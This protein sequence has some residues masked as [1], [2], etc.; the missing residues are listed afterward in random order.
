MSSSINFPPMATS[1]V[2]KAVIPPIEQ[3]SLALEYAELTHVISRGND[4]P[5]T[6]LLDGGPGIAHYL[7]EFFEPLQMPGCLIGFDPFGT[8][9]TTTPSHMIPTP[10]N[11]ALQFSGLILK[12]AKPGQQIKIIAHSFGA[13]ILRLALDQVFK[14]NSYD[15]TLLLIDPCPFTSWA[16]AESATK[17][18]LKL[19]EGGV[20]E[21]ENSL[22]QKY[23]TAIAEN[24]QEAINS[25]GAEMLA[26]E[27]P[28]Y[29]SE[30]KAIPMAIPIC[31]NPYNPIF[32]NSVETHFTE[33]YALFDW[34]DYP[35]PT[36][37]TVVAGS[38]DP[39]RLGP[40]PSCIIQSVVI[41]DAGHYSYVERPEVFL[42]NVRTI[43][44]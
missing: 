33:Q 19:K 12:Y 18:A 32:E 38:N 40:L 10:E 23:N 8:G 26:L 29:F 4:E 16:T 15:L 27:M 5:I 14:W 42:D 28:Y 22:Q 21:K 35:Y 37:T 2:H 3:M 24:N 17:L 43:L 9:A 25:I 20:L 39:F 44:F 6:F 13:V 1:E 36:K 30:K 11:L 7:W 34:L 41:E 31:N